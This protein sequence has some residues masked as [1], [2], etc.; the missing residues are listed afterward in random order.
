MRGLS[1]STPLFSSFFFI[2]SVCLHLSL[3]SSLFLL[4]PEKYERHSER[5]LPLFFSS[6]SLFFLIFLLTYFSLLFAGTFGTVKLVRHEPTK[7]RYALKC[8]SRK[9]VVALNQ[10]HHIRLEREI[11]AENDHPFI[12]RLGKRKTRSLL[13]ARATTSTRKRRRKENKRERRVCFSLSEWIP[14]DDSRGEGR[15]NEKL[16]SSVGIDRA[17]RDTG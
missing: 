3:L 11:M 17:V 13:H 7:I 9:S 4:A 12:I 16:E 2:F 5:Y 1:F 8:V 15:R 6:F 14:S 10:Q